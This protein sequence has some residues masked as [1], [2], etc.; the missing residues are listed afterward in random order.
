VPVGQPADAETTA[1]VEE[2]LRDEAACFNEGKALYAFA[3]STN[4]RFNRDPALVW[5]PYR[6][7]HIDVI[8]VTNV[9]KLDDGR[10]GAFCV[11]ALQPGGPTT[12]YCVFA[13]HD[14]RWLID[15]TISLGGA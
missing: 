10:V 14:T 13:L 12:K 1:A 3:Y 11:F 6:I 2:T 7:D 15:E 9:S 5:M 4:E 8:S